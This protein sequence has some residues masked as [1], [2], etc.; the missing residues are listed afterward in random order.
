MIALNIIDIK[1]FMNKLLVADTFDH[2][3][4]SEAVI[5]TNVTYTIDGRLNK[6]FY[7]SDELQIQNLEELSI[8]PFSLLKPACFNLIKGKK[9]PLSFKFTFQLSPANTASTLQ[10]IHSGFSLEDIAAIFFHIRFA[11]QQLMCTTGISYKTFALDHTLDHEWDAL[12]QRFL[13]NH[14]IAFELMN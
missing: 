1:D 14:K 10:S 6:D 12:M 2:F 5:S 9:T 7:S 11:N 8:A 4:L 3:L 13:A